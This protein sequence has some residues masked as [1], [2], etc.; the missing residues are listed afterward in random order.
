MLPKVIK[1]CGTHG[2]VNKNRSFVKR[3]KNDNRKNK[4]KE[5]RKIG[6]CTFL[7]SF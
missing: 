1:N 7:L 4:K 6:N 2:G 5:K 3:Y